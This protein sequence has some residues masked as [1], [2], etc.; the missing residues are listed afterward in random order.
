MLQNTLFIMAG[1][2]FSGWDSLH[3]EPLVLKAR[4]TQSQSALSTRLRVYIGLGVWGK[5]TCTILCKKSCFRDGL[6]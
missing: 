2:V 6:F 3:G 5:N 1:E 4:R